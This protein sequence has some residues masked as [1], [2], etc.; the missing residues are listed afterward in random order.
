MKLCR[1]PGTYKQFFIL[2]WSFYQPPSLNDHN[3]TGIIYILH[4]D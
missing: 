1:F 3:E 2:L 4:T